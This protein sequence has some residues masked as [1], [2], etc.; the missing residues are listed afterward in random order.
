MVD[1]ADNQIYKV[2]EE[3]RAELSGDTVV[4]RSDNVEKAVHRIDIVWKT[5]T[6]NES[7]VF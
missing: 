1:Q 3:T 2:M 4:S 6:V 7:K 5:S